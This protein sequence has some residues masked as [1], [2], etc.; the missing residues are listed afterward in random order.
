MRDPDAAVPH[1]GP[2]ELAQYAR[3]RL[4]RGHAVAI[5]AHAAICTDCGRLL[6]AMTAT[7]NPPRPRRVK[8]VPDLRTREDS[9]A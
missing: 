1:P 2:V 9:S 5:L 8:R 6:A 7:S 4:E 3:G